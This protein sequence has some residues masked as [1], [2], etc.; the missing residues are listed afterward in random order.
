MA[1]TDR[2]ESFKDVAGFS[3]ER[4]ARL[5]TFFN[6]EVAQGRVPGAVLLIER[7]GETVLKKAWGYRNRAAG[8]PMTLDTI[9]RIFSMTKPMVSIVTMMLA[10]EGRLHLGQPVADF[11]PSFANLKVW[12]DGVLVAPRRPPTVHDLLR[13]TAGLIYGWSESAVGPFYGAADLR[14]R[15]ITNE[16]FADRI[17]TLPLAHHPGEVWEYS[18]ATDVLGRVVEVAAGRTL[19]AVLRA[20]LTEPLGM[21]DTGFHV[22]DPTNHERIAE[23]LP[24]DTLSPGGPPLFNPRRERSFEAGG[25]GLVSTL[26]DYARFAR[27][28]LADGCLDDRLYLGKHTLRFMASDHIGPSTGIVRTRDTLLND[29]FGFGLGFAVR[30]A[31]GAATYPGSIGEF[32]WS[33]IAGTYFWVDPENDLFALLL[34]Q[35]PKQRVRYRPIV[36]TMVY[37]ALVGAKGLKAEKKRRKGED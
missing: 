22:T 26:D 25:M 27:M 20:R 24:D 14:A 21:V 31:R 8:T 13:H 16:E 28:L 6:V 37:D 29:G 32:N 36:K 9:F 3:G 23:A 15:D 33:G 7:Q 4:L 34:T 19:G 17:A 12:Q 35:S 2:D 10:A 30:I 18:H 1:G 11:I 5:D